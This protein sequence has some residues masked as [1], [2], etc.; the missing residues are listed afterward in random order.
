MLPASQNTTPSPIDSPSVDAVMQATHPTPANGGPCATC[1]FRPG[2]EANRTEHTQALVR[3][4]VEGFRE[5]HCHEKPQLC[6]GYIAAANLRG[7]PR[8]KAERRQAEAAGAAADMLAECISMAKAFD[9]A[10]RR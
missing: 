10:V 8:T 6:R 7:V 2:S 5:F 9:E 1:A 3:L 4:S